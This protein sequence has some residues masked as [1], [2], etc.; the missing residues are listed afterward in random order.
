VQPRYPAAP[1]AP[2]TAPADGGGH[3]AVTRS[4]A[5]L[6]AVAALVGPPILMSR[7]AVAS[8]PSPREEGD[9]KS[10]RRT[11]AEDLPSEKRI[12]RIP[13]GRAF[14]DHLMYGTS[15]QEP[16]LCGPNA[17]Y[18]LLRLCDFGVD[19]ER[20]MKL[21]PIT[22]T[23]SSLA[24]LS[25]A[26]T[27]LGLSHEVRKVSP[28]EL[29]RLPPPFL[30]HEDIRSNDPEVRDSGHF[31]VI[32]RFKDN[33]QIG[34]IDGV[35]GV[36]QFV[37]AARFDRSFSGYVMIPRAKFLGIPTR[38]AWPVMYMLAATAAVLACA[39]AYLNRPVK[40]RGDLAAM[41]A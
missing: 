19:R 13:K 38:W 18:V 29:F 39:L 32:V 3:G 37:E 5:V 9:T 27:A 24:D 23:G 35:S 8:I 22:P 20:V 1:P 12:V 16:V 33:G 21:V 14:P 15:W 6:A 31:F 2:R 36:Y 26:A 34:I 40:P 30:V 4:V 25:R 7:S 11:M 28:S 41:P 17:L 10:G